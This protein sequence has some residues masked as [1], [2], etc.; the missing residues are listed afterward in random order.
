MV[1]LVTDKFDQF[2]AM[3]RKLMECSTE[4]GGFRYIPFRIYQVSQELHL[5][6]RPVDVARRLLN[7]SYRAGGWCGIWENTSYTDASRIV[8]YRTLHEQLSF[9][10]DLQLMRRRQL[11]PI[12]LIRHGPGWGNLSSSWHP[13]TSADCLKYCVTHFVKSFP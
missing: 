3:N 12:L 13:Q 5:A 11:F 7:R 1:C 10:N 2:W 8:T 9:N 6:N 4:E